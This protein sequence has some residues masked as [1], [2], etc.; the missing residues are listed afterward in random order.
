MEESNGHNLCTIEGKRLK[1]AANDK[2]H[3]QEDLPR[4]GTGPVG[5]H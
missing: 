5:C 2:I 1:K 4:F 3:Q